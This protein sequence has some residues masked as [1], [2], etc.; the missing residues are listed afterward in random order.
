M[1]QIGCVLSVLRGSVG[2]GVEVW[3]FLKFIPHQMFQ[4]VLL[5]IQQ[6]P[7]Q[8]SVDPFSQFMVQKIQKQ[9]TISSARNSENVFLVP[10]IDFDNPV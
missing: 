1:S 9:I 7:V 8:K 10:E 2:P 6:Q 4:N 5:H 3:M